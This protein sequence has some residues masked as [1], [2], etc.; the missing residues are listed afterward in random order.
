MWNRLFIIV[1]LLC[2][3]I[4]GCVTHPSNYTSSY[5]RPIVR[6]HPYGWGSRIYA[7]DGDVYRVQP[8]AYGDYSTIHKESE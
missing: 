1:A 4:T 8:S 3:S 7:P 2:F 6:E 5:D